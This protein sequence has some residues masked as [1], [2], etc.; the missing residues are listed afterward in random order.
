M[1]TGFDLW[2]RPF[3]RKVRY[4]FLYNISPVGEIMPWGDTE[5]Q[6]ATGRA[7]GVRSLLQFHAT[8]YDDPVV[9][10]RVD[11]LRTSEGGE[12]SV[13]GTVG[14]LTRAIARNG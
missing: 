12:A 8:R 7:G 1:A 14:L 2:Q 9:R 6:P 11:L 3:Y 13:G 5:D 4:F 10:G